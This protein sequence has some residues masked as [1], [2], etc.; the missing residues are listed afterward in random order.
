[1]FFIVIAQVLTQPAVFMNREGVPDGQP[2]LLTYLAPPSFPSPSGVWL[3]VPTLRHQELTSTCLSTAVFPPRSFYLYTT[4][5]CST[6]LALLLL[7]SVCRD[8]NCSGVYSSSKNTFQIG[9][10]FPICHGFF[11]GKD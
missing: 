1:M 8:V 10:P 11:F 2:V 4:S 9:H 3:T 6:Q 7:L 5:C